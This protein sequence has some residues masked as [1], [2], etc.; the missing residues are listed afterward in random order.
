M[1]S[2]ESSSRTVSVD[3]EKE[4]KKGVESIPVEDNPLL[5]IA[6]SVFP[7]IKFLEKPIEKEVHV[8]PIQRESGEIPNVKILDQIK[9]EWE[10][11]DWKLRFEESV[12]SISLK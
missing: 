2:S 11:S 7:T 8:L 10:I 12:K 3:T 4:V 9:A 1:I 5:E 6:K